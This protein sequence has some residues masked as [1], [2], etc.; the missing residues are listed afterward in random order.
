MCAEFFVVSMARS[1][2]NLLRQLINQND[3]YVC[4][5]EIFRSKGDS[6]RE[7]MEMTGL[8]EVEVLK[9]ADKEKAE[10]WRCIT[11]SAKRRPVHVG[12]KIFYYHA[13]SDDR[14]WEC[15]KS[16]KII[17]LIRGNP[18]EVYTSRKLASLS[19][20]WHTREYDPDYDG[21]KIDIEVPAFGKW[22]RDRRAS[23]EWARK[24][25]AGG[26]YTEV[27]YE[28]LVDPKR[29][30]DVL[31][32]AL[33]EDG[34]WPNVSKTIVRQRHRPLS[35]IIRNYSEVVDYDVCDV[36]LNGGF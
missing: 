23:I 7:I 14:L 26:D 12:A 21:I 5:G 18:L 8:T 25:L 35:E 20:V 29:Q 9:K 24:Y 36:D 2:T 4:L 1:G 33:G 31:L 19:N 28:D 13:G 10:L 11:E 6:V 34:P 17:H 22:L 3:E 32:K 27:L 30:E 15:V 16:G